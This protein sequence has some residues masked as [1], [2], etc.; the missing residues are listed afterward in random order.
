MVNK[1]SEEYDN[2]LDV[3]ICRHIDKHLEFYY[4]LGLTPNDLTTISL[5]SGL[6]SVYFAYNEQY[7]IASILWAI[8]Y[9]YDCADGK[10]ARKYKLTSR[11]GDLYDHSSDIIKH[12]LMFYVLYKKISGKTFRTKF[13]LISIIC[14]ISLLT[15]SQLG[16][17]EKI[18]ENKDSPTLSLA[19]SF[20]FMEDCRAQTK[21]TKYFSPVTISLYII[22]LMLVI[23][24]I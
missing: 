23:N 17:Q 15:V 16:C 9:Y 3:I 10:L 4:N 1:I 18:S 12:G 14:I 20:I 8:A 6:T 22:I 21:Y 24:K 11:F 13:I 19:K 5:M 7:I 2:P